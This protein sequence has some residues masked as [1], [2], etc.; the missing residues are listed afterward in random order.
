MMGYWHDARGTRKSIDADGWLHTG[1][2][3]EIDEGFIRITGRLK[4]ILVLANGEKVAPVDVE[5]AIV[6]DSLFDQAMVVGEQ[7]PYLT[8]LL[9]LNRK[10]W[11]AVADR[12]GVDPGSADSLRDPKVEELLL[13]R[14]SKSMDRF[15]GYAQIERV[16]ATLEPWTMEDGLLTPTLKLRR[17][18]VWHTFE[19]SI[20]KMYEGYELYRS[21]GT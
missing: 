14:I 6:E 2:Q 11:E 4:D 18:M 3:A 8:A 13:S 10:T 17:S 9:V 19:P 21:E 20:K 1:D 16:A 15:P 7:M 12:L 5:S